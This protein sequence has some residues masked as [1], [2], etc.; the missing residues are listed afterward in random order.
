MPKLTGETS[1]LGKRL[2]QVLA[3]QYPTYSRSY[4][5]GL[6]DNGLVLVNGQSAKKR[7]LI[8][9]DDDIQVHFRASAEQSPLQPE[10]IPLEVLYEDEDLL[11]VNKCVGLVT[12]P[13]AGNWTG[14][15]VHAL[16]HHCTKLPERDSLRPGIVHRLD[17]ETSGVLI[18]A[19][20]E[21]AQSAL[22]E[23]FAQRKVRKHYLALTSRLPTSLCAEFP[24]CRD[25]IHRKRMAIGQKGRSAITHFRVVRECGGFY[26]L[27]AIPI[28]GRTHQIRVHLKAL[29]APIVGDVLYGGR[30]DSGPNAHCLLHA[31][32]LKV[33]HPSSGQ[34]IEFCAPLP[35]TFLGVLQR[36]KMAS[37]DFGKAAELDL[38]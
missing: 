27:E 32:R 31:H 12:H 5:Q 11:V 21:R 3:M 10:A 33:V 4:F 1:M 22:L 35:K 14:T 7:H 2:D 25:R 20:T 36:L 15:F 38:G 24:I 34:P 30:G 6:I 13:G 26:L 8:A 28:T 29:G 17:R 9:L 18:A 16:L 23:Q 19:K 37:H